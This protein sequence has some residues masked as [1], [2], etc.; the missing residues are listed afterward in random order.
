MILIQELGAPVDSGHESD[1]FSSM[2]THR[3]VS[4]DLVGFVTF[5]PLAKAGIDGSG[6]RIFFERP[7]FRC[8][9]GTRG[10][11]G[12]SKLRIPRTFKHKPHQLWPSASRGRP[13]TVKVM[14][15]ADTQEL[16]M[17]VWGLHC[18]SSRPTCN[19]TV[20]RSKG[21]LQGSYLISRFGR[22]RFPIHC[23]GF[24]RH[25]CERRT[26]VVFPWLVW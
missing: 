4:V 1:T 12:S 23:F 16:I 17:R 10:R 8:R 13:V 21:S 6:A 19:V 7:F 3:K 20:A 2:G 25:A 15:R 5:C 14:T 26:K 18:F 9:K 22:C 11:E 24:E